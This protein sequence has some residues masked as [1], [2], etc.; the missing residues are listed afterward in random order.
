M[1]A[2]IQPPKQVA[3][4][5]PTY[6]N[7]FTDDEAIS[8]RHLEHYLGSYDRYFLAPDTLEISEPGMDVV[9]FPQP[10]FKSAKTYSRL[11]LSEKFYA[12]FRDYRYILIYQLDC[13]VFSDRL[14]E[15]CGKGYDY[16]GAPWLRTSDLNWSYS[17]PERA[18]NGGF[19][20]RNVHR[21]IEAIR[22][23]N[24]SGFLD[25]AG[26]VLNPSSWQSWKG[27]KRKLM[28]NP[29]AAASYRHSED[30]W[31]SFHAKRYLSDFRVPE[32]EEALD[33]AFELNPRSSFEKNQHQLPFGCHAWTDYDRVFWEPYLLK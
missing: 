8:L 20:L 6:K 33:F 16:V 10:Y 22:R 32:P 13:L 4:V 25:L 2:D 11:L 31:W 27:F 3:V 28:E 19:S 30:Y 7:Q 18:G 23:S 15:W 14:G 5:V 29:H 1:N 24:R 21:C 26:L 12:A 9:S 17:G